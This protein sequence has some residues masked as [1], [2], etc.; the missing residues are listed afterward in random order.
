[1]PAP[2]ELRFMLNKIMTDEDIATLMAGLRIIGPSV[3]EAAGVT[4]PPP[5]AV[6]SCV[7]T[8]RFSEP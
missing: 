8:P 6:S 5:S 2:D 3:D 7:A 1:M 4:G